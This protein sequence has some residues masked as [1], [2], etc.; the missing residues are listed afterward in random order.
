MDTERKLAV[1][2]MT[3]AAVLAENAKALAAAGALEATEKARRAEQL[4]TGKAKAERMGVVTPEQAFTTTAEIFD[5]ASWRLEPEANGFSAKAS[6][7][8]LCAMAKRLGAPSPCRLSCLDPLEG[9]VRGLDPEA[10]FEVRQTLFEGTECEVR[11]RR[12][13]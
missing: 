11:V 12:S 1:V 5:C 3:Y 7:C 13:R 2:R 9:M 6:R 10:T 4:S 8:T